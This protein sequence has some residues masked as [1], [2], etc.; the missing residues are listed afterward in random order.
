MVWLCW[1]QIKSGRITNRYTN[2]AHGI[3]FAV[4][5][6]TVTG[7]SI[8]PNFSFT[9]GR[10]RP[11]ADPAGTMNVEVPGDKMTHRIPCATLRYALVTAFLVAGCGG[12]LAERNY[13]Y[14]HICRHQRRGHDASP[15]W[16]AL[17]AVHRICSCCNCVHIGFQKRRAR[18]GT[19]EAIYKVRAILDESA[20]DLPDALCTF[21]FLFYALHIER[22]RW[23][24][25]YQWAKGT[26]QPRRDYPIAFKRG[27]H[28]T[29]VI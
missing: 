25:N 22:R 2:H 26:Q 10:K 5:A 20:A 7:H 14:R 18:A 24:G 27:V 12:L 3:F 17:R 13:A 6:L 11:K 19:L 23:T 28:C 29:N 4:S 9:K 16:T 8:N 1:K 21:Q 15:I